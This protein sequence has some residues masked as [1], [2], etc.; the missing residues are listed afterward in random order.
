VAVNSGTAALHLALIAANIKKGDLVLLPALTFRGV[1]NAVKY[2]GATPAYC[3]VNL[4]T[5]NMEPSYDKGRV[6]AIIPTHLYG[7][8][9][10]MEFV[11]NF[12][13]WFAAEVIEDACQA[14]GAVY[15]GEDCGTLGDYSCLSFNGNKIMTTGGGGLL[16]SR[17][18]LEL[19][20][21][22]LKPGK[23]LGVGYNYRM[24]ALNA[25][26]GLAQLKHVDDF[27]QQKFAINVQ[28]KT[29][30]GDVIFQAQDQ[31]GESSFWFTACRF[32]DIATRKRI[33]AVIPSRR[34]FKPLAPKVNCPNAWKIYDTALCLPS[35][36]KNTK[37]DIKQVC[38]QIK[39][40]I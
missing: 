25:A 17:Y 1:A 29:S 20:H 40:I 21:E 36:V 31:L 19:I 37:E 22:M 12:A 27:L 14:F 18:S 23:Y 35:S 13:S 5:W 28:Y 2:V 26:L 7:N 38:E 11:L 33:E 24:P 16:T 9:C 4:E 30:L 6:Q 34:V 10:N 39:G 8:P 15:N 32:K 3:D